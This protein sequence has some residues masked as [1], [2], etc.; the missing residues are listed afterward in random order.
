M[1]SGRNTR[2]GTF[3]C[4]D[5]TSKFNGTDTK[6][7]TLSRL[8][9]DVLL[10]SLKDTSGRPISAACEAQKAKPGETCEHT[11]I[12]RLLFFWKEGESDKSCVALGGRFCKRGPGSTSNLANGTR[13]EIGH[14]F[15]SAGG[16]P[17]GGSTLSAFG[18]ADWSTTETRVD[19]RE[20]KKRTKTISTTQSHPVVP[21]QPLQLFLHRV[22]VADL[23]GPGYVLADGSVAAGVLVRADFHRRTGHGGWLRERTAKRTGRGVRRYCAISTVCRCVRANGARDNQTVEEANP[24]AEISGR[25]T[26]HGGERVVESF[27]VL[28]SFRRAP[29]VAI[30]AVVVR[31][32]NLRTIIK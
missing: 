28:Q 17:F 21:G 3:Y 31:P 18:R 1:K 16:R 11:F 20:E 6:T 13:L 19:K 4:L 29:G 27:T 14:V 30:S 12:E 7:S 9:G 8:N 32:V 23:Q 25:P 15:S 24:G 22:E 10:S 26:E 5:W 2:I